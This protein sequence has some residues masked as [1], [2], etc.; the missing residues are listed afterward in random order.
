MDKKQAGGKQFIPGKGMVPADKGAA[1][2]GKKEAIP[3]KKAAPNGK[4]PVPP[5][6]K[7]A[8]PKAVPPKKK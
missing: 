4:A 1:P 7:G 6:K 8:A 5:A 2:A 3:P